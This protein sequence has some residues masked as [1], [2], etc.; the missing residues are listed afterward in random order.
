M[1]SDPTG[2]VT[3]A[4]CFR[5]AAMRSAITTPRVRMPTS[6]T[7]DRS[8]LRSRI[9]CAIRA[10]VRSMRDASITWGMV[11]LFADS[12]V[13]VKEPDKDTGK[14]LLVASDE[15]DGAARRQ[16]GDKEVGAGKT[17]HV[18]GHREPEVVQHG[19]QHVD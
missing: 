7:L 11:H 1:S 13:R 17:I 2:I 19:W 4:A 12:P 5:A 9:S 10:R 6:A 8:R 16:A 15:A 18:A 14:S 3:P